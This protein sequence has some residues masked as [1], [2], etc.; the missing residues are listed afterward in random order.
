MNDFALIGTLITAPSA[1][2]AELRQRPR[3]WL[4]LA[5]MVLAATVMLVWYF[6]I[7]DVPWLADQSVNGNARLAALPADTRARIIAGMTRNGL[8]ISSLAF[9]L[10]VITVVLTGQALYYLLAGKVAGISMSYKHWFTMV[11]WTA[12]PSLLGTIGA[13]ALLFSESNPMQLSL[14]Q[15]Q[16]LSLNELFFH[17]K[18]G[19]PGVSFLNGLTIIAPLNWALTIVCVRCWTNRSWASSATFALLPSVLWY[20]G[21]ALLSFR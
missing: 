21:W 17:L 18:P 20:S 9:Y 7:V 11:C 5:A 8:L 1:A 4:P 3:F 2:F 15:V 12:L 16:A 14:E 19:E 6:S 10:I 13:V